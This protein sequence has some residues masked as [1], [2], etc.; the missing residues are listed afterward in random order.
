VL[1][2]KNGS[3]FYIEDSAAPVKDENGE[4]AG[5]VLVFR[6]VTEKKGTPQEMSI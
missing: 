5:V 3:R 4:T 6:D 1:T 2:S